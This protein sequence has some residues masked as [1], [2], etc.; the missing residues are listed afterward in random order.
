[1]Q[2]QTKV[3]VVMGSDSDFTVMN[4]ALEALHA[5]GIPYVLKVVSA[6]RTPLLMYEF[7]QS[8]DES[9]IGV[10]IAGAGGAAHLPGMLAALTHV[11]VIGVPV[12]HGS[13]NGQDALYS[14]VQMPK[15]IPVATV[16]IGGAF[17]AG[18]LAAQ[19][20]SI[21]SDEEAQAVKSR[22]IVW[23]KQQSI[24]SEGK[25]LKDPFAVMDV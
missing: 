16:A 9:G 12:P 10:I 7:A 14:I 21:G 2:I 8:A 23:R 17:N 11:P 15:G 3:A 4:A 24:Q 6:H 20:L 22:L 25:I 13:L 19:M 5:L 18:I 1:M